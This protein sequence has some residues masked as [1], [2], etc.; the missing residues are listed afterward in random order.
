[1]ICGVPLHEHDLD[2]AADG[3]NVIGIGR[4]PTATAGFPNGLIVTRDRVNDLGSHHDVRARY[5]R[6]R[7]HR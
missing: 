6:D 4:L 5:R 2:E 1:M 3:S 7:D